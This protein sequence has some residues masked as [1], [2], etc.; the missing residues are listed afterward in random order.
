MTVRP[1]TG[2]VDGRRGASH[3]STRG[4]A[5]WRAALVVSLG[6]A[7]LASGACSS[8]PGEQDPMSQGQVVLGTAGGGTVRDRASAA[9]QADAE[10]ALAAAE[11]AWQAGDQ[12][13]ALAVANQAIARGAPAEI[14]ARLREL[15][16]RARAAIVGERIVALRAVPVKDVVADG[17]PVPVRILLRNLSAAELTSPRQ[18][19]DSSAALFVL[20]VTREDRD[21]YGNAR[22]S[23][24]TLRAPVEDDLVL[25]PGAER[26]V[27]VTIAPDMVRLGHEGFSVFRIGGAFRPVVVRVG[28]AELFDALPIEPALV[29]VFQKGYEPLAADPLSALRKA[30]ARRSPPH[31]LVAAELVAAADRAEA[32][33]ILREGAER[34]PPLA[35]CLNAALARLAELEAPPSRAAARGTRP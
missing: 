29:R 19:K 7:A 16:T 27:H 34:D 32:R 24:F 35:F 12:L 6:A 25:A 31:V 13:T 4:R 10:R 21:V 18:E 11:A 23:E 1:A 8:A 30:V 5:R 15:R 3:R 28:D 26:E 20:S 14:D 33:T 22:T 2:P 9:S 17:D